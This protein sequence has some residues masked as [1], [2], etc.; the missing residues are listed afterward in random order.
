MVGTILLVLLILV[1]LVLLAAFVNALRIGKQAV[2]LTAAPPVDEKKAE[3]YAKHLS[4]MIQCPTINDP[5]A[6]PK[7]TEEAFAQMREVLKQS[8]PLIHEKLEQTLING[9]GLLYRWK[10]SDSNRGAVVLMS[11]S[12]VVPAPGTWSHGPFSGDIADE[13]IWGRGTQDTKGSLCAILEAVESL[14]GDD[15][16]PPCDVYIVSSNNEETMGETAPAIVKYLQ[17][18]GVTFDLVSD[19]G[20]AVISNPMP[21]LK[22]YFAMLGIVEK[23]YANVRFTAKSKGGHASAPPK[24]T[25][26]ARLS[27]F[28]HEIETKNPFKVE[29]S[30]PVKDMFSTLAPYM[31]LPFR[32]IFG[33]LWLTGPLLK[34]VMGSIS[35]QGGAMLQTTC[36]FTMSEGSD[37]AN[38]IPQSASITANMRFVMHQPQKESLEIIEGIAKKYDLEMEVLY[39]HDCSPYVDTATE[40]YRFMVETVRKVF[41]DAGVSPYVMVGGTDARHFAPY[42]DCTLRFAPMIMDKQQMSSIHG[43]DENL[44]VTSLARGVAFY[45]QLLLDYK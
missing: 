19:E 30:Q 44:N 26:I 16:I 33:N 41:P 8:F 38:V 9:S 17:E 27:A 20:G 39:A 2:P 25:P 34:R 4:A 35:P 14:L 15:F 21:G 24:N 6:D 37:A 18:Q 29:I 31:A 40:K 28:V 1:V 32:F 13:R 3:I 43:L 45:R 7:E 12:D 42:C 36:A 22:D 10:G 23:G 5:T 11:H